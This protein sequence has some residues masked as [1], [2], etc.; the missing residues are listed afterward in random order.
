MLEYGLVVPAENA[1][2]ESLSQACGKYLDVTGELCGSG[3][4]DEDVI[5]D[6]AYPGVEAR[7]RGVQEDGGGEEGM[8]FA[9]ESVVP[10][11]IPRVIAAQEKGRGEVGEGGMCGEG[12][13]FSGEREACTEMG[14]EA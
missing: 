11:E 2:A 13:V 4:L 12:G 8:V 5:A 6:I 9:S 1:E 7:L 3:V 14:V 10:D